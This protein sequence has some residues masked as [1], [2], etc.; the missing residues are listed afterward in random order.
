V[1]SGGSTKSEKAQGPALKT[2]PEVPMRATQAQGSYELRR[3]W[4]MLV[5]IG[6]VPLREPPNGSDDS[7]GRTHCQELCRF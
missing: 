7:A 2:L 6:R 1:R 4:Q 3:Q 5:F